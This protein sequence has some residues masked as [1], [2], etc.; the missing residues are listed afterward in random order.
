VWFVL[1]RNVRRTGMD[2]F[3]EPGS[4]SGSEP[5]PSIS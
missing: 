4:D 3:E 1:S 5:I 2:G